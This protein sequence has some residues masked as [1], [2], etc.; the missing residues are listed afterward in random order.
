[1]FSP[2]ADLAVSFVYNTTRQSARNFSCDPAAAECEAVFAPGEGTAVLRGP[3]LEAQQVLKRRR[4]TWLLGIGGFSGEVELRGTGL[5][6]IRGD[7]EFANA[8]AYLAL[9]P[10]ARVDVTLGASAETV[11]APVGLLVPRDSQIGQAEIEWEESRLSPKA[12]ITVRPLDGMTLRAAAYWRLSP[13][14]GRIQTLEPTQIAGFNQFFREPGGTRSA[15]YGLGLDQA[16]GR[17]LFVGGQI[18]RRD[19]DVPEADCARPDPTAGCQGQIAESVDLKENREDLASA[20]FYAVVTR[21][22]TAGLEYGW[23]DRDL[24]TTQKDNLGFFQTRSRTWT[25]RPRARLFLPCGFFAGAGATYYDQEVD[26]TDDLSSGDRTV[27][28]VRFWAGDLIV[29]YRLPKR[30]GSVFVEARNA[31]DRGFEFYDRAVEETV[32]PDRVVRAGVRLTY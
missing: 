17:R 25:L 26:E 14:I 12:G 23:I 18:L 6:P 4:A 22:L 1:V 2:A 19:L 15:S 11:T 7:D 3:Q 10:H 32:V 28:N 13:A 24:G 21:R 20:Y 27:R 16:I 9:R 5:E 8:Y 29:G 30:Y 31:T